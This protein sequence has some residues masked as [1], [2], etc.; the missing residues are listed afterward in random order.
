MSRPDVPRYF[1]VSIRFWDDEKSASWPDYVKLAA[2]Y[3]MTCKHRQLEGIYVLPIQYATVD[4]GWSAKKVGRAIQ[5]LENEGFLR[6]DTSC[7]LVLLRNS[8]K[9]QTPESENVIKGALR[10]IKDLPKSPLLLEFLALAKI[11]CFRKG[12][13]IYAQNFYTELE[14]VLEPLSERAFERASQQSP[15][16]LNLNL[17]PK[18]ITQNSIFDPNLNLQPKIEGEKIANI[19][20]EQKN[21]E[22]NQERLGMTPIS[23]V[24][25]NVQKHIAK[26]TWDHD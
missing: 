3:Y 15:G 20:L 6:F 21:P 7:N 9:Y 14:R 18:P 25:S 11:H 19:Q 12:A 17:K 1:R 5:V 8:L 4:I 10:R 26:G 22:K 23:S 2:I 16:L 13:P 24:L